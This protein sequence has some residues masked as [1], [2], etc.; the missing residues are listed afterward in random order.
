MYKQLFVSILLG[1]LSMATSAAPTFPYDYPVERKLDF[2]A[3]KPGDEKKPEVEL[4]PAPEEPGLTAGIKVLVKQFR[5]TGN[6]VISDAELTGVVRSYIDKEIATSDLQVIRNL[7]TK[8]YIEKG[9]INSGAI[10]PDQKI[11]E[12]I[13]TYQIIEGELSVIQLSGQENLHHSYIYDR[14]LL[15]VESP[16]NIRALQKQLFIIQQ[17]PRV[18]RVNARLQP[19]SKTGDSILYL[20]I[21]EDKLYRATIN[22]NN[23]RPPSVGAERAE[24]SFEHL[25]LLG[26][27]DTINL[28]YGLTEGLDDFDL[29]YSFPVTA[30]DSSIG[31]YY[32]TSDS[33]VVE[34]PF[35]ALNVN[36][37]SETIGLSSVF[38][39]YKDTDEQLDF[40]LNIEKRKSQTFL[41]GVPYSFESGPQEGLSRVS[42]L[43]FIQSWFKRAPTRVIAGRSTFSHGFD[44]MDAT[45]NTSRPDGR[46]QSWLG[47]LQLLERFVSNQSDLEIRANIQLTDDPLLP[48]EQFAI[49]GANS[50]RGYREN[51]LVGD[52][53]INISLEY[54]YPI[55]KTTDNYWQLAVFTDYGRVWNKDRNTTQ[56]SDIYST[57]LG[58]R[59]TNN[60]GTGFD[61]YWGEPL[62]DTANSNSDLQ[63]DGVHFQFYTEIL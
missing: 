26:Y 8:Y 52:N 61:V 12:G 46:F 60:K 5:F 45:I 24:F 25:S 20:D 1:S 58:V 44:A 28:R 57:G 4:P 41:L 39:I 59:W 3:V 49:G 6:S 17:D 50:V 16:L 7:L 33:E 27:G 14:T 19:G 15:G 56:P 30:S 55:H 11:Q 51:Q 54:R 23:H 22:V 10:L 43:R 38:S 62:R 35:S 40:G 21:E 36:S 34:P 47:Q 18:K 29:G 31:F 2:P 32:K 13:V 9:Y 63:D 42:V 53:G 37:N 48:L